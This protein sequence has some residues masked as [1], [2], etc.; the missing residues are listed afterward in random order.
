MITDLKESPDGN[1]FVESLNRCFGNVRA[2]L[3]GPET[4]AALLEPAAERFCDELDELAAV[5]GDLLEK[6]LDL[7]EQARRFAA[8]VCDEPPDDVVPF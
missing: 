8:R 4:V 6:C 1:R 2:A 3:A 7:Q 5:R